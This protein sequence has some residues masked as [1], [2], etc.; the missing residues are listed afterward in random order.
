MCNGTP[1]THQTLLL[2]E[3]SIMLATGLGLAVIVLLT[4]TVLPASRAVRQHAANA[5]WPSRANL[6][7]KSKQRVHSA[8]LPG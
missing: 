3:D 8:T 7:G 2:V 6:P 5:Q 1:Y 4:Y